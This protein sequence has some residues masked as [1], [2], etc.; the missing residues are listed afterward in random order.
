M[1]TYTVSYQVMM[2]LNGPQIVAVGSLV[3][4]P[5]FARLNPGYA[6]DDMRQNLLEGLRGSR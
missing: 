6:A 4:V 1:S 3:E 2:T 5:T